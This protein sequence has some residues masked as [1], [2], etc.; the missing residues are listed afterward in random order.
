VVPGSRQEDAPEVAEV[1]KFVLL[2]WAME[3]CGNLY[4]TV[5]ENEYFAL[6]IEFIY[7]CDVMWFVW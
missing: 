6:Y 5:N 3:T 7:I 1:S 4:E 2:L